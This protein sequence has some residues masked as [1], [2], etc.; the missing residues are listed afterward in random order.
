MV[1]VSWIS[2]CSYRNVQL[3]CEI[4][5]VHIGTLLFVILE[6]HIEEHGML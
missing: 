6:E 1:I 5:A 4:L 3:F 2:C